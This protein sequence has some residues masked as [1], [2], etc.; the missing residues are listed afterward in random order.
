MNNQKRKISVVAAEPNGVDIAT[1]SPWRA[2]GENHRR[3]P[4]RAPRRREKFVTPARDKGR[5]NR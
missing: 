4:C 2:A 5:V 1:F 3:P